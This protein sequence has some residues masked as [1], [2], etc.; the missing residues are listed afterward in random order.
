[1]LAALAAATLSFGFTV[2][3]QQTECFQEHAAASMRVLGSWNVQ[4]DDFHVDGWKVR[5]TDPA[6]DSVYSIDGDRDGQFDYYA[7][8]EG[9]Y[10]VCFEYATESADGASP[11]EVTAKINVGDPPDLIQ[12]AKTEHLTPIEERIK[13][14]RARAAAR[15]GRTDLTPCCGHATI[16]PPPTALAAA[17]AVSSAR[18]AH[19]RDTCGDSRSCTSRSTRCA[20]CRTRFASK[21]RRSRR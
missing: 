12:L 5:V 4:A 13:T 21:T 11:L 18:A 6:G 16:P 7:T 9:T 2:A 10:A 3:P 17:R 8:S 20:T 1:M 15:P 19:S 14:V